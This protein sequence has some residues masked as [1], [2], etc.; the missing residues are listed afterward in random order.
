MGEDR[1]VSVALD[2]HKASIRLSAVCR[3]A[4]L[5]E[6]TLP[7]DPVAVERAVA[8][9]PGV[10]CCYE[11]GRTGFDLYRYLVE[12]GVECRVVALG[13]VPVRPGDRIKTDRRDARKL[14]ALR[15]RDAARR[16]Q[17]SR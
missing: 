8:R 15:Q 4:L 9:W 3:D 14:A 1:A 5:D 6:R 16:R 10:S 12:R 17:A 13:L 7:N 2:V 11:A